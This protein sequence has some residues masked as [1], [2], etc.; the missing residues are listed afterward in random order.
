MASKNWLRTRTRRTRW[1]GMGRPI[2][3][4]LDVPQV[5]RDQACTYPQLPRNEGEILGGTEENIVN[6]KSLK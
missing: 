5:E 6:G 2:S 1:L 3:L 4:I